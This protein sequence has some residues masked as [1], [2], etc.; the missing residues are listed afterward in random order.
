M[1]QIVLCTP[2]HDPDPYA[3]GDPTPG[4]G[5]NEFETR[6]AAEDALFLMWTVD[7]DPGEYWEIRWVDSPA[8]PGMID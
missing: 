7:L 2:N 8:A 4:R 1:Y 5:I 6:E 3:A